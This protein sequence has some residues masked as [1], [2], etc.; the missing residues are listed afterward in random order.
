MA[1]SQQ[2]CVIYKYVPF[3]AQVNRN[4]ITLYFQRKLMSASLFFQDHKVFCTLMSVCGPSNVNVNVL[5][6]SLLESVFAYVLAIKNK[7]SQKP[8]RDKKEDFQETLKG[9]SG[10]EKVSFMC[11]KLAEA[12]TENQK[13]K[14]L[15]RRELNLVTKTP[16][17]LAVVPNSLYSKN[18]FTIF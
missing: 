13:L 16:K 18:L 3:G 6:L 11:N 8:D 4:Y 10:E 1:R 15:F 5:I 2:V 12:V 14:V 17:F 9:L 7:M